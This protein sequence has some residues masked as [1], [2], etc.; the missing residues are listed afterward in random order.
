MSKNGHSR[1][2]AMNTGSAVSVALRASKS[3]V[4][5]TLAL[6]VVSAVDA[7]IAWM[8]LSLGRRNRHSCRTF[9]RGRGKA[10]GQMWVD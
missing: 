3:V 1:S 2:I 7:A 6:A 8:V 5:V 10:D 4:L 9:L